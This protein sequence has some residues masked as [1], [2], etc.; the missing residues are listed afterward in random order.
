MTVCGPSR[1]RYFSNRAKTQCFS[2]PTP[3]PPHLLKPPQNR[4]TLSLSHVFQMATPACPPQ[5]FYPPRPITSPLPEVTI[6]W[7][8]AFPICIFFYFLP[9]FFPWPRFRRCL[10]PH[11]HSSDICPL[12]YNI[13]ASLMRAVLTAP[14][15]GLPRFCC[16]I[17]PPPLLFVS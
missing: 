11:F 4:T 14:S 8:T 3:L 5:L 2:R 15:K 16:C 13:D 1:M 12:E 17:P 9:H 10:D 7:T 6:F